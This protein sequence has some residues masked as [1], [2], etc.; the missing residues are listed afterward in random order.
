MIYF[1]DLEELVKSVNTNPDCPG[2]GYHELKENTDLTLEFEGK[3]D[4]GTGCLFTFYAPNARGIKIQLD[5]FDLHDEDYMKLYAS[6][7]RYGHLIKYTQNTN[8][9]TEKYLATRFLW[10]HW[11]DDKTGG[12][13]TKWKITLSPYR[14]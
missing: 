10:I 13:I 2:S 12:D 4:Q 14:T 8:T 5:V 6:P 3:S 11:H 7:M 9:Q 1:L